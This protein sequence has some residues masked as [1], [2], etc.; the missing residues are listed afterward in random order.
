MRPQ[1]KRRGWRSANGVGDFVDRRAPRASGPPVLRR[2]TYVSDGPQGGAQPM[3]N[4]LHAGRFLAEDMAST[5]FFLLMFMLTKNVAL[6]VALGM[7]LGVGQVAWRLRSGKPVDAMQWL[8]LVLVVVFGTASLLTHDARFI[9]FKPT[10]IYLVVGAVMLKP[11]WMARYLPQ[12][13]VE[14]VP[15]VATVFGYVW[16]AMMFFSA[17]LNLVLVMTLPVV[18]WA[19]FMSAWG[20]GSKICL[21]LIQYATMRMIGARRRQAQLAMA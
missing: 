21:F 3:K 15:D 4:L 8:S 1:E 5:L 16:S 18:A 9:M 13:A 20:L 10:L 12:I 7:A 19:A 6:S 2:T 17:G 11:G 14:T